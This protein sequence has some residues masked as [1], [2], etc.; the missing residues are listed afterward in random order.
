MLPTSIYLN[1]RSCLNSKRA[2][3]NWFTCGKAVTNSSM[4]FQEFLN[5]EIVWQNN[6]EIQYCFGDGCSRVVPDSLLHKTQCPAFY[7]SISGRVPSATITSTNANY[8][9]SVDKV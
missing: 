7:G 8:K 4:N 1:L 5:R 9:L 3:M 6:L 2:N